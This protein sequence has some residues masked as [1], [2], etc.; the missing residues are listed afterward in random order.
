MGRR[1][2]GPRREMRAKKRAENQGRNGA[3]RS[4]LSIVPLIFRQLPIPRLSGRWFCAPG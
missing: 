3:A 1:N 4:A 2:T